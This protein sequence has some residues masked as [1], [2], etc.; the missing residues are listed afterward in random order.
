MAY[1]DTEQAVYDCIAKRKSGAF[2]SNIQKKTEVQ[3]PDLSRALG[4]LIKSGKV[5]KENGRYWQVR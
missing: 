4:K 5:Y 1:K 2:F 3:S